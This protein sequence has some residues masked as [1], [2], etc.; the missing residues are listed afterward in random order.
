VKFLLDAHL[1]RKLCFLFQELGCESFHTLDLP[2]GNASTDTAVTLFADTNGLV[3][4]T[5]DSDFVDSHLLVQR[6]KKLLYLSVGNI[7]NQ[8]LLTLVQQNHEAI[9]RA[10][11][12]FDFVELSATSLI[13]HDS[14]KE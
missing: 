9:V 8:Y 13:V 6:P 11:A 7:G 5:K 3:V 12:E 10:L 4:M 2:E 14:Q 1:P